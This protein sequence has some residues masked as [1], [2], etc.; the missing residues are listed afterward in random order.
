MSLETLS[1]ENKSVSALNVADNAD[2]I[3]IYLYTG[4]YSEPC[5]F[6]HHVTLGTQF[7][8]N[9]IVGSLWLL[10]DVKYVSL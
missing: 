9:Y 4:R 5:H 1:L 2:G 7:L 6:R 10:V 8:Y 3:Y